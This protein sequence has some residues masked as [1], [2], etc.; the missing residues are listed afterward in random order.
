MDTVAVVVTETV[1]AV[2]EAVG[3]GCMAVSLVVGTMVF[4]L[5]CW[6]HGST[7][8]CLITLSHECQWQEVRDRLKYKTLNFGMLVRAGKFQHKKFSEARKCWCGISTSG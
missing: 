5:R 6:M 1:A 3:V 2:A 7:M 8:Q 4:A